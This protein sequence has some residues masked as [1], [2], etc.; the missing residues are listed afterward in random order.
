[1]LDRNRRSRLIEEEKI[2]QK[3]RDVLVMLLDICRTLARQGLALRNEHEMDSNF[4]QIVHLVGRY[5]TTMKTWLTES[6]RNL[7]PFHA[8]YMRKNCQ[9]EY[10][11]LLGETIQQYIL[12]EVNDAGMIGIIADTTPD[13]THVDQL[14]VGVR[15]VDANDKPKERLITTAEV[16]ERTKEEKVW[17]KQ[18]LNPFQRVTKTHSIRFQTYDSAATMSGK[19]NGAQKK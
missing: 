1:M 2:L 9:E 6:E 3:Q 8:T 4:E 11:T 15:F 18:Y 13:I 10:I 5:N 16:K 14:T 19:Y 7:R 12:K 17:Q